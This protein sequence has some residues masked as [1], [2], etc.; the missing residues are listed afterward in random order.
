MAA[1]S[2]AASFCFVGVVASA[3][4]AARAFSPISAIRPAMFVSPV[5]SFTML[6]VVTC[7]R[8]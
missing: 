5:F 4:A 7:L 6:T 1:A 2:S 8:R 3:V